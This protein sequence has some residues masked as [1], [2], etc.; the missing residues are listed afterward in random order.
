[1]KSTFKLIRRFILIL[2]LSLIGLV[3]INIVLLVGLTYRDKSNAGGWKAAGE[4]AEQLTGSEADGFSLTDE[5]RSIL[6]ER[7][8]WAIL[9]E[10]GTGNVIWNSDDLP[11]EVPLHY[12]AAEISWYTRGYIA[13]YPTTT[14]ARGEDLL[15]LGYPKDRYWKLMYPTWDYHGIVNTPKKVLVF[16]VVN[17]LCI[18]SIYLIATS[19]V[20]RQVKPIVGGIEALPE[21]EAVYIREKGL[22]SDLATAINRVSERLRIQERE[23]QKK[24][25]ARTNWIAGV[26]HD[27]RTPLSMVMGY[28]GQLE[29]D[30]S[31]SEEN[32]R[33]AGVIRQQSIR[34]KNLVNDLNLASKLEYHMQSIRR[35]MFN[36][37]AVVRRVVVDFINAD[38][39]GKYPIEWNTSKDLEACMI[40]GDKELIRRAVNNLILNARI[41]N[42]KGCRI[43]VELKEDEQKA[44]IYIEDDGVG[45]TEE[46]LEEIQ[47]KPHYLMNQG[48]MNKQRHGLGL[49]IVK[50]IVEVHRGSVC[51]G[52]GREGGFR[53]QISL[54]KGRG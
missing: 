16:L 43:F 37:V 9:I 25:M 51:F 46:K 52:Q 34:M 4:V 47:N 14:A 30:L 3:V 17:L 31:L 12:S 2:M 15:V 35:E 39:E 49:L 29:E 44:H 10:D 23:L 21:G 33:K 45:V 20:L 1:M 19:G 38:L 32:R 28:A 36:L 18:I 6:K 13:D 5:G 42:P 53:V 22:L 27:I 54:E 48:S 40:E 41:H 26:S 11:K 7:Q 8:A 24:E 50:Q